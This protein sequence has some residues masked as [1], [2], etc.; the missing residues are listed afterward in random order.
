MRTL[1]TWEAGKCNGESMIAVADVPKRKARSHSIEGFSIHCESSCPADA[2]ISK[3]FT[4]PG[5][6]HLGDIGQL[7]FSTR[8]EAI[9][10]NRVVFNQADMV[11]SE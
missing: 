7:G 11:F 3:A 9:I 2:C 10:A 8:P 5:Y 6:P 4:C 1:C